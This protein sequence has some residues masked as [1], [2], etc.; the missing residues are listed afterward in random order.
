MRVGNQNFLSKIDAK[1]VFPFQTFVV[2]VRTGH[3]QHLIISK[4]LFYKEF[5]FLN[6][7]MQKQ[8][9]QNKFGMTRN[10]F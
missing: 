3:K 9:F 2:Y 1:K 7:F 8:C 5:M 6:F 10:S 4:K